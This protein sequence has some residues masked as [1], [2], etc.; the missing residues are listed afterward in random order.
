MVLNLILSCSGLKVFILSVPVFVFFHQGG[1]AGALAIEEW[2]VEVV[3]NL[4]LAE[5]WEL[6]P[7]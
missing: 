3:E 6:F 1:M 7:G 2:G 5:K 4:S